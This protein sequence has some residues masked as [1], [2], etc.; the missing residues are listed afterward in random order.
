VVAND[1]TK[2]VTVQLPRLRKAT[3]EDFEKVSKKI[4][5]EIGEPSV[6]LT[7]YINYLRGQE[8]PLFGVLKDEMITITIKPND[9]LNWSAKQ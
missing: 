4:A 5:A 8:Q 7:N 1:T 9:Q 2:T 6:S 3:I